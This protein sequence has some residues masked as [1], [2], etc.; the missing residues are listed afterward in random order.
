MGVWVK[1]PGEGVVALIRQTPR[2]RQHGK[3]MLYRQDT[4]TYQLRT[5]SVRARILH[6]SVICV[7]AKPGELEAKRRKDPSCQPGFGVR[8]PWPTRSA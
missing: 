1:D 6:C 4:L 3:L 8:G 5:C 7:K 2:Q